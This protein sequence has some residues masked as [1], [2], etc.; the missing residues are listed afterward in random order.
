MTRYFC[1]VCNKE[2]DQIDLIHINANREGQ[3]VPKT[4]QCLCRSYEICDKCFE[5]AFEPE[6]DDKAEYEFPP[7]TVEAISVV[8][9]V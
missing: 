1:D 6:K 4:V 2:V 5:R 8:S 9:P 3:I 7:Q